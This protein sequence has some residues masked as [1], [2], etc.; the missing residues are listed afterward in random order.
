[1]KSTIGLISTDY[2]A[3]GFGALI[4]GRTLATLPF[5]GRYRLLDFPLSSMVNSGIST[6]G[7][8]APHTYR[9]LLDHVGVGKAW[10]LGRKAG[11]L[12]ILPGSVYGIRGKSSRFLMRDLK[13]NLLFFQ[14]DSADY[15]LLCGSNKVYNIDF[16]PMIEAHEKSGRPIT[17]G[18]KKVDDADEYTGTFLSLS[19][20]GRV[21]DISGTEHGPANYYIDCLLMDRSYLLRFID[22]FGALEYMDLLEI[23]TNNLYDI[24]I[25]AYEFTGYVGSVD[26]IS[27]YMRVS[28]DLLG[29][30]N[31]ANLFYQDRKIYT[32]VQDEAPAHYSPDAVVKNSMIS[33]GCIIEGTVENSILFRNCEVKKGAVVRNSI[34]M[35][36]GVICEGAALDYVISDKYVTFNPGISI[37]GS[38]S[39]PIIV[40]KS[41]QI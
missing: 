31:R 9:S 26:S 34:V 24:E 13:Q 32:K 4:N 7:M 37:S 14:K 40:G 11:G 35:R 28:M 10:S 19:E 12:F 41:Q 22:W 39:N 5:G 2:V 18:Y 17:V 3:D 21:V 33:T 29:W 23:L 27:D 1:M 6:V 25:G 16:R 30:H 38:P 8:L 36:R 20:D 15:V